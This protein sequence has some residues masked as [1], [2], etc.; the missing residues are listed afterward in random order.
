M[1]FGLRA[2]DIVEEKLECLSQRKFTITWFP[3]FEKIENF[4]GI[5]STSGTGVILIIGGR[6]PPPLATSAPL[7]VTF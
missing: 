2:A 3:T 1:L 6:F 4:L 5:L 7:N